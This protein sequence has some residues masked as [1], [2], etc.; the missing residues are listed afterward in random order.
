MKIFARTLL[1][2]CNQD[3]FT[4]GLYGKWGSGKTSIV[5]M[6]LN[7]IESI[8][9]KTTERPIIIRF[10]PWHFSDSTQLLK[11]FLI[12]LA[13]EFQSKKD[14]RTDKIGQALAKYSTA[15][16]FDVPA[17]FESQFHKSDKT[18][19]MPMKFF[20]KIVPDIIMRHPKFSH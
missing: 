11:Q 10:E 15:F 17:V 2:S 16:E 6:T 1:N 4:I 13:N 3:T 18:A 19:F 5:N 12:R 14:K 9:D 7:E 20:S 8:Q